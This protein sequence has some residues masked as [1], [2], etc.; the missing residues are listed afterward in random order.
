M[1]FL[2]SRHAATL[3][4]GAGGGDCFL[5]ASQDIVFDAQNRDVLPAEEREL[6]RQ[7]AC[8]ATGWGHAGFRRTGAMAGRSLARLA[9]HV[10]ADG[11][12]VDPCII[13]TLLLAPETDRYYPVPEIAGTGC[14]RVATRFLGRNNASLIF[15]CSLCFI[16]WGRLFAMSLTT[17]F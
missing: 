14:R 5:P 16:N 3:D 2:E 7:S 15:Y 13:A 17:T 6:A 8:L 10:L 9:G 4:G 12:I 1:G 11:G